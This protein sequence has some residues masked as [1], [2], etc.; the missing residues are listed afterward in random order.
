MKETVVGIDIGGSTTK[1][2]GFHFESGKQPQLIAPQ[3]VHAADPLTSLYGAFGKFTT[4]NGLA[5]DSINRVM[6]TGVGSSFSESAIYNLPTKKASEFACIALGGLYLSGLQEAIVVSMGTGTALVHAKAHAVDADG[7]P[8][9][10]NETD[11]DIEYLGG[12]GVG[13]GT[14]MGLSGKILGMR[15]IDH[16]SDLA[17]GGDLANVDLRIGDI[18]ERDIA[19]TLR[20]TTTASNFGKL[21]DTATKADI[22]LGIINLVF[23]TVGMVAVFAARGRNVKD[24]VLTGTLALLPQAKMV[25]ASLTEM[26]GVN[27]IIPAKAQYATAIGASLSRFS[28]GR[29]N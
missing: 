26:F 21:S 15:D 3:L 14:L 2:V 12:T 19:S 11:T 18:S 7:K 27:F 13:G 20:A 16:I 8:R 28:N 9:V 25:F 29:K 1:I 6:M 17:K 22:A 4:Q 10:S 5:L 24:I 23:E